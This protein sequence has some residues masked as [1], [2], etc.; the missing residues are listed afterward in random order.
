MAIDTPETAQR[1]RD[2]RAELGTL[3]DEPEIVFKESSPRKRMAT[4]YSM[5]DGEPLP[6]NMVN[7]ERVLDKRLPDGGYMFTAKKE[8]APE[9]KLGDVKCFLHLDSPERAV[10]REIGLA[11]AYCPAAHLANSHS[12]RIHA[13]HRHSQEWAAYQEYV[14]EQKEREQIERQNQ[15]LEATLA[16][17]GKAATAPP[18]EVMK[19]P[20][21]DYEGSKQQVT[22]H[23]AAKHR[24]AVT[25]G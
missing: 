25:S 15:Q 7:I 12:K 17:A 6:V 11:G 19:C 22:G 5:V 1:A 10:L 20:E 21:C 16:I 18:T 4:I 3:A 13:Q 9:Y 8:E 23:R 14:K 2:L 24:E